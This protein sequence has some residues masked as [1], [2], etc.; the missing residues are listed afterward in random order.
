VGPALAA[1]LMVASGM[2]D[3]WRGGVLLLVYGLAMTAPFV[4]AALFARP[5]LG[6]MQRNRK[7]LAHV[8]KVMGLMLI[9]FAILI[10]TDTVN[11]IADV[12]IRYVPGFS[13]LG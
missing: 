12:M 1:I 11:L 8:E 3:I 2:G 5:F 6:W 10:A 4:V 13:S 9:I 7:Y